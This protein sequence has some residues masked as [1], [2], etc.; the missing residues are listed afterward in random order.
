[1]HIAVVAVDMRTGLVSPRRDVLGCDVGRMVNPL[2]VEGQLVGGV[3]QGIGG[4][5]FEELAYAENGQ[6]L[7]TTFMDY[8]VATASDVPAMEVMTYEGE[9]AAPGVHGVHGVGEVATAGAGAAMASAVANALRGRA[10]SVTALPLKPEA[11]LTLL[12]SLPQ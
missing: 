12:P 5:L 6:L 10:A 2:I 1:V 3:A 9:A 11:V 8:A 7:T 4:A